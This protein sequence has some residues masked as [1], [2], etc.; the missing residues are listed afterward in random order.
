MLFVDALL[1]GYQTYEL[2]KSAKGE[3]NSCTHLCPV[4]HRAVFA[5]EIGASEILM[6]S[7]LPVFEHSACSASRGAR[8]QMSSAL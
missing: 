1:N 5:V 7:P 6:R 4:A 2:P 3:T 8:A